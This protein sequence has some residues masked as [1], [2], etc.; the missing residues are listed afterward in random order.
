MTTLGIESATSQDQSYGLSYNNSIK[1]CGQLLNRLFIFLLL[2]Q[3]VVPVY[4]NHNSIYVFSVSII[5]K[6]SLLQDYKAVYV[7]Q[8]CYPGVSFFKKHIYL[9]LCPGM[10]FE[11]CIFFASYISIYNL[12]TQNQKIL[13]F[14]TH[15]YNDNCTNLKANHTIIILALS[16]SNSSIK[17]GIYKY[18]YVL[19]LKLL[20]K[21]GHDSPQF[22]EHGLF[23]V[24]I[25]SNQNKE[26]VIKMFVFKQISTL[27]EFYF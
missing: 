5:I 8:I 24:Y 20:I 23:C 21:F 3:K 13:R 1:M 10:Y 16:C 7:K 12:K 2:T 15:F 6:C 18:N 9:K 22:S 26:I 17:I 27:A 11:L 4:P 25:K 14:F 19:V